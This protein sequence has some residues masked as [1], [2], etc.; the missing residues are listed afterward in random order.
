M[1]NQPCV[2]DCHRAGCFHAELRKAH[3]L[4]RAVFEGD[5]AQLDAVEYMVALIGVAWGNCVGGGVSACAGCG[6][7]EPHAMTFAC[8]KGYGDKASG[9]SPVRGLDVLTDGLRKILGRPNFA[10]YWIAERLR[11]A[12]QA[13]ERK[14]EV[15]QAVVI[16][17]LLKH[18]LASESNWEAAAGAELAEMG[19]PLHG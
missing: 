7:C 19:R 17:Y 18:Y 9:T 15:E 14:S 13:I 11:G 1:S 6:S 10:C 4:G 16:H 8:I 5:Q 3:E 12:G 2:P